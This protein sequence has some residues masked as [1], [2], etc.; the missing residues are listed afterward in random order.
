MGVLVEVFLELV[1]VLVN[2]FCNDSFE[3]GF[4]GGDAVFLGVE[5]F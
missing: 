3:A 5:C 1:S 4:E 2:Q